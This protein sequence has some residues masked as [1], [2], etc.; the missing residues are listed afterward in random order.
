MWMVSPCPSVLTFCL[1]VLLSTV[2][3]RPFQLYNV[4][5][6]DIL[7][8]FDVWEHFRQKLLEKERELF[9]AT[10]SINNTTVF[11]KDLWNIC[12][13]LLADSVFYLFFFYS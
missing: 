11:K 4:A 10:F 7:V 1:M 12:M 6:P 13:I 8:S 9:M 3:S 2:T 5:Q